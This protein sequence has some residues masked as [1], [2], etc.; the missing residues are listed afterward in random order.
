MNTG[1]HEK[2]TGKQKKFNFLPIAIRPRNESLKKK[3][4][5]QKKI[6]KYF[7]DVDTGLRSLAK[8]PQM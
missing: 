6:N 7:T 5:S 8:V 4:K 2:M 3:T 1:S